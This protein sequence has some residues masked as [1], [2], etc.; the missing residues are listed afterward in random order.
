MENRVGNIVRSL[1]FKKKKSFCFCVPSEV[2][3]TAVTFAAAQLST[4][5]HHC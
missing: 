1:S 4:P 2:H 5:R 3:D